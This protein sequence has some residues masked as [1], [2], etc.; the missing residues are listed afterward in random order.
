MVKSVGE[1]PRRSGIH[2]SG[3]IPLPASSPCDPIGDEH[4]RPGALPSPPGMIEG[5]PAD[6]EH[7][8]AAG[9]RAPGATAGPALW[10]TP[11]QVE[12]PSPREAGGLPEDLEPPGK[13]G[14]QE[15]AHRG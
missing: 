11:R 4:E 5:E 14:R 3:V 8:T 7:G 2:G 10:S 12:N 1:I 9:F 6:G 13:V 15:C